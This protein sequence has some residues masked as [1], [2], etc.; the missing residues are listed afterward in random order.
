VV[1]GLWPVPRRAAGRSR[2]GARLE[3]LAYGRVGEEE[4]AVQAWAWRR[5]APGPR[6]TAP[7][8]RTGTWLVYAQAYDLLHSGSMIV[9]SPL[10]CLRMRTGRRGAGSDSATLPS[11]T[12]IADKIKQNSHG[13]SNH[14]KRHGVH[15]SPALPGP[16]ACRARPACQ[17]QGRPRA[18]AG[19]GARLRGAP[20]PARPTS[21]RAR[22]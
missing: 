13:G 18:P 2:R 10:H 3:R 7:A 17:Q 4:L 22:G 12:C 14:A 20:R 21:W 19:R 16:M 6:T 5:P 9:R 15:T 1:C 11:C 8:V